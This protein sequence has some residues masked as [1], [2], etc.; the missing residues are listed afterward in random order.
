MRIRRTLP[1]VLAVVSVAAALT[2]AVQLRKSAPPEAA[3]FLPSGD[4]FFYVNVGWARKLGGNSLPAV[5]HDP[6]YEKFIEQTGIQFERDLESAAFSIHYPSTW[7]G[8]GT[9]GNAPEPRF[10][11]VFV[12]K[13]HGEKLT[14]LLTPDREIG[15]QLQL[16]RHFHHP[17]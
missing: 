3:R 11:E 16:R 15:G 9:G 6:A 10:S 17:G 4:A 8:G 5:S 13:F 2:L 14:S 7:G 12:G 1:L